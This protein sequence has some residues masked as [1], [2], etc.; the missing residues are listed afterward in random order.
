MRIKGYTVH[1][2]NGNGYGVGVCGAKAREFMGRPSITKDWRR[3]T[4]PRC[5][6]VA[7]KTVKAEHSGNEEEQ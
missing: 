4:C 5:E 3:V 2:D 6:K 7:V 1:L